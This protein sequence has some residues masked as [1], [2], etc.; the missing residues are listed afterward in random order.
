MDYCHQCR[1]HL[2]GA[3]ACAGCGTPAWQLRGP[4]P[5]PD[6]GTG[7]REEPAPLAAPSAWGSPQRPAGSRS[8][9]G[10]EEAGEPGCEVVELGDISWSA[11]VSGG[12]DGRSDGTRTRTRTR[13]G[14]RA[15]GRRARRRRGRNIL[16]GVAGLV[17][18]GGVLSLAELALESGGDGS[19]ATVKEEETGPVEPLPRPEGTQDDT[20]PEPPGK[21]AGR[22]D[23]V[24]GSRGSGRPA[25]TA[26]ARA[27]G[28]SADRTGTPGLPPGT[29]VPDPE[30]RPTGATPS[31]PASTPGPRPSGSDAPAPPPSQAPRPTDTPKPTPTETC[32]PFL[33]W[34]L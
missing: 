32:S 28:P 11:P 21:P 29:P 9:D 16:V 24:S 1:R 19:S 33:W 14:R 6:P 3:L 2:N 15:T 12:P 5:G 31:G 27:P 22:P 4:G 25:A 17:L 34:C 20:A 7:G 10:T 13:A 18:A 8:P 30:P 26:S 23:E